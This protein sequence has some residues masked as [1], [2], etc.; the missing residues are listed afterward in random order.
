VQVLVGVLYGGAGWVH[1]AIAGI[2]LQR[3]LFVEILRVGAGS[4]TTLLA[5]P[6]W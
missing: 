6:P 2:R 1:A 4:F 3:R 5:P